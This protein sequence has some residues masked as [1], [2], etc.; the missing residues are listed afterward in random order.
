MTFRT[1]ARRLSSEHSSAANSWRSCWSRSL[2]QRWTG[3]LVIFLRVRPG[4]P[5]D[6]PGRDA[7]SELSPLGTKTVQRWLSISISDPE[8]CRISVCGI[9]RSLSLVSLP[10]RAGARWRLLN[11]ST[12]EYRHRES[13]I[14]HT[15]R[16][17]RT[18]ARRPRAGSSTAR[19][20]RA[21]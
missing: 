21:H 1:P 18:G 7:S 5:D 19:P 13:D 11:I 4:R 6:G 8:A 10:F 17:V 16:G 15:G 20:E 2:C 12:Q 9:C 14:R 3:P